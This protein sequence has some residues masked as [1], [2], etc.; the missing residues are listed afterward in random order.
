MILPHGGGYNVGYKTEMKRKGRSELMK[1]R[2]S[3]LMMNQP[4]L[5]ESEWA[6]IIEVLTRE[7]EELSHRVDEGIR[8]DQPVGLDEQMSMIDGILTR[9]RG[10][11]VA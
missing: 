5:S 1:M 10:A 4:K 6:L 7:L 11:A 2:K 3:F 8:G 9:I